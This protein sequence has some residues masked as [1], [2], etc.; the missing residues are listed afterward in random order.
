[1]VRPPQTCCRQASRLREL[2]RRCAGSPGVRRAPPDWLVHQAILRFHKT[3]QRA[4][5]RDFVWSFHDS[6]E[7]GPRMLA[8]IAKRTGL[9][10]E[11]L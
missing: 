3:L 11:D 7:I 8:R 5:W 1:M 4:G 10:P 6:E 9:T 2:V